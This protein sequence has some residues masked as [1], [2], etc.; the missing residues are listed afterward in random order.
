[1]GFIPNLPLISLNAIPGC[2]RL[3]ATNKRMSH[4]IGN[5]FN[6]SGMGQPGGQRAARVDADGKL[7][8]TICSRLSTRLYRVSQNYGN[9][10]AWESGTK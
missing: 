1:M 3:Q 7:S 5:E 4:S 9:F 6:S 8:S 2:K 10:L